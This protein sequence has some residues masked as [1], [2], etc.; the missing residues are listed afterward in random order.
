MKNEPLQI[1]IQD[2]QL[3]I[4]VGIDTLAYCQQIVIDNDEYDSDT[5]TTITDPIQFAKDV[6]G[7][8]EKEREDGSTIFT[9]LIDLA[10]NNALNNGSTGVEYSK[11][12]KDSWVERKS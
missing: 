12:K 10:A 11:K 8:L 2:G 7:A 4:S 1:K 6:C 5:S 9:D 3:V